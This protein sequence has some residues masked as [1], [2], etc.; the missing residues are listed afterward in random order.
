MKF[1]KKLTNNFIILCELS[2]AG[3]I[4]CVTVNCAGA[5]GVRSRISANGPEKPDY[6]N[7]ELGCFARAKDSVILGLE[8]A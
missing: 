7:F 3:A 2:S 1:G 5:A 4:C 6:L 8:K